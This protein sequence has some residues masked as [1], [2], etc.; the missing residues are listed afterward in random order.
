MTE[1]ISVSISKNII[2]LIK[3]RIEKTNEFSNVDE[4]IEFLLKEFFETDNS[5]SYTKEEEDEIRKHL[6]DMGYL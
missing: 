2:E 3:Q 1:K 5:K 6:K 4:Y